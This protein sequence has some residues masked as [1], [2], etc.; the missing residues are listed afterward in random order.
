MFFTR[1][2][3]VRAFCDMIRAGNEV[4]IMKKIV[5]CLLAVILA[6]L[7][8]LS[9]AED[10]TIIRE[11]KTLDVHHVIKKFDAKTKTSTYYSTASECYNQKYEY[12]DSFYASAVLS[13]AYDILHQIP[14]WNIQLASNL[15]ED[16]AYF[17]YSDKDGMNDL[18]FVFYQGSGNY[19][20]ADYVVGERT[21][22][23]FN[24]A[25]SKEEI[26]NVLDQLCTKYTLV[27]QKELQSNNRSVQM[28]YNS[29]Y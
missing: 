14:E 2:L 16:T 1:G 4:N 6:L 11:I 26:Q 12:M 17:G 3:R 20:I 21:L 15:V 28:V 8:V 23:L 22:V 25:F 27:S 18:I 10:Y 29:I 7:P 24:Q 13:A 5:L 19:A 9:S